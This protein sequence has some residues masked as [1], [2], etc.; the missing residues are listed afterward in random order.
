MSNGVTAFRHDGANHF[1]FRVLDPKRALNA[2]LN[3]PR[4][5]TSGQ[6]VFDSG[7]TLRCRDISTKPQHL[8]LLCCPIVDVT[9][10]SFDLFGS[11]RARYLEVFLFSGFAYDNNQN[12]SI[13]VQ[14]IS[15]SH[16]KVGARYSYSFP[17][18]FESSAIVTVEIEIRSIV[19]KGSLGAEGGEAI[20]HSVNSGDDI[21][22]L[23]SS[24]FE[25]PVLPLPE[26]ETKVQTFKQDSE[27]FLRISHKS[28]N[29]FDPREF[30]G[31]ENYYCSV[32]TAS[33]ILP[34]CLLMMPCAIWS[35]FHACPTDVLKLMERVQ[36]YC[37]YGVTIDDGLVV[38]P[39][40]EEM[41]R[42]LN[43]GVSSS[44]IASKQRAERVQDIIPRQEEIAD[45][46]PVG[47]FQSS[48]KY[49]DELERWF[50]LYQK[51]AITLEEY[52]EH[53]ARLIKQVKGLE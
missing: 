46:I 25:S 11:R 48:K 40:F 45:A 33:L 16:G 13:N 2:V 53:K 9:S 42:P 51:G 24:C 22:P 37:N 34:P 43:A 52:E 20:F 14:L 27:W 1:E 29:V 26:T 41:R 15:G 5:L 6:K 19:R 38:A 49:T 23:R 10:R 36:T 12:D 50:A 39:L 4:L 44:P 47:E 30:E 21:Q 17:T 28:Y 35:D 32:I 18:D 31:N 3:V 7:V 8:P